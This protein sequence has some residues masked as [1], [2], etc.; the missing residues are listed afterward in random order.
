MTTTRTF[1]TLLLVT[2]ITQKIVLAEEEINHSRHSRMRMTLCTADMG[3]NDLTSDECTT[4]TTQLRTCYNGMELFPQ[5][6][7]W[8]DLDII[9]TINP[10]GLLLTR[11]FF[12][13]TNGTCT[14]EA[15]DKFEIPMRQ[16]VGPFGP[17]QPWGFFEHVDDTMEVERSMLR[18]EE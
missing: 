18:R 7:S 8:S 13:S 15:S 1:L 6:D 4:Y 11:K 17:P 16:C 12:D 9:D 5:S 10:A 14:G 3:C 2:L